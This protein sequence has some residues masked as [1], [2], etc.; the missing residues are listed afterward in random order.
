M[1]FPNIL[2]LTLCDEASA[3]RST[4]TAL[5]KVT[6]DH[7]TAEPEGQLS[8]SVS[9]ICQQPLALLFGPFEPPPQGL[10]KTQ[11]PALLSSLIP[12]SQPLSRFLLIPLAS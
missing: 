5:V 10:Q 8:A 7:R 4:Q 2:S 6:I 11:T 9:G 12:P 3:P 1:Y